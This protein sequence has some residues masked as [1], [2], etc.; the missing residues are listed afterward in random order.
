MKSLLF[1]CFSFLFAINPALATDELHANRVGQILNAFNSKPDELLRPLESSDVELGKYEGRV[2]VNKKAKFSYYIHVADP[3]DK[4]SQI[5]LIPMATSRYT[6]TYYQTDEWW[7]QNK[8]AIEQAKASGKTPPRQDMNEVADWL[9]KMKL[10]T[11]PDVIIIK[12]KVVS[13]VALHDYLLDL[14]LT[15]YSRNGKVILFRGAERPDEQ[16]VWEKGQTPKGAR[17]WTPTAN[18]AWRYGRKNNQFLDLFINQKT[19]VFKFEVPIAD[20]KQ[21]VLKKWRQL[22]LGTELTKKAHSQFPN[23]QYFAD[24]LYSNFPFLGIGFLGLELEV[25]SNKSGAVNM[26][27]YYAGAAS[28]DDLTEERIHLLTLLGERLKTQNPGF[29]SANGRA[30]IERRIETLKLEQ[31]IFNGLVAGEKDLKK[32]LNDYK[33]RTPEIGLI[34]GVNAAS[35]AEK[36]FESRRFRSS[37]REVV[38]SGT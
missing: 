36:I 18:Y 17:Y 32:A 33:S 28:V 34:D 9:I 10:H 21:M 35:W 19:P 27:R 6:P 8:A 25:R 24:H 38:S 4:G 7:D 13:R 31:E 16:E 22:T 30:E 20:F 15:T 29:Y 14:F 26:A 5:L 2:T 23:L 11:N 3:A 1:G 37:C 12:D